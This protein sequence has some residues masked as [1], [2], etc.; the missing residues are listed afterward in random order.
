MSSNPISGL[1]AT[2]GDLIHSLATVGRH[3]EP[4]GQA[5]RSVSP[6]VREVFAATGK[7]YE[8][9]WRAFDTKVED[10]GD[11]DA[12]DARAK[13]DAD[14]LSSLFAQHRDEIPEALRPV[15]ATLVEQVES[16][17]LQLMAFAINRKN[18]GEPDAAQV[19]A[20]LE[21]RRAFRRECGV[22]VGR[23][24]EEMRTLL[25]PQ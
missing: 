12:R 6:A 7:A 13:T 20:E 17:Q 1:I 4:K 18:R 5:P 19:E 2:F 15:I 8:S 24:P 3:D 14:S 16:A 9:T 22:L 21:D 10:A 23:L 11:Y 25:R